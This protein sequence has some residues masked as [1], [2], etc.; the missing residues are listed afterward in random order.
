MAGRSSKDITEKL[1]DT[2]FIRKCGEASGQPDASPHFYRLFG[3]RGRL[4]K[5]G[6]IFFPSDKDRHPTAY[7][8][9][10]ESAVDTT[11]SS[12]TIAPGSSPFRCLAR[13]R[14]IVR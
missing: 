14:S 10:T 4:V 5:A 13:K 1:K 3:H 9:E 11:A 2:T 6:T 8:A 7:S 12:S